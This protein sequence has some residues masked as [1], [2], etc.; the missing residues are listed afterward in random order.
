MASLQTSLGAY[1]LPNASRNGDKTAKTVDIL[2]ANTAGG[3]SSAD[4]T[5]TAFAVSS[6]SDFAIDYVMLNV[7]E[8]TSTANYTLLVGNETICA[9]KGL[10]HG[11]SQ[12]SIVKELDFTQFGGIP[13]TGQTSTTA[14]VQFVASN[15]AATAGARILTVQGHFV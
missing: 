8:A 15:A 5:L 7:L 4:S 3:A 14:T 1:F 12:T 10:I 2:Q 11:S 9:F 13:V 6:T